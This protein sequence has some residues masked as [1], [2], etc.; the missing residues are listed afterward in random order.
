M[1]TDTD[2]FEDAPTNAELA[3]LDAPTK[4][5][6][7]MLAALVDVLAATMRRRGRSEEDALMDAQ[8][9]AIAIAMYAGGR[10]MYLPTGETLRKFV[11]D[12]RLFLEY[13]GPAN[14]TA[15]A[16]RY[17]ITERRVE[18][19]VAE[20]YAIHIRRAQGRLFGD[21]DDN[22]ELSRPGTGSA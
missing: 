21:D 12:R 19:I 16:E 18:Q 17:G 1:N 8:Q 7:A 20:Q 3:N 2:L 4:R 15:L 14:K 10:Q 22:A 5:W 13:K 6:P 11:R 9:S